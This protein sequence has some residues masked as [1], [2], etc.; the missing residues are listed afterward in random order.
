MA[1]S[2]AAMAAA[3][4]RRCARCGEAALA[5][6]H[7]EACVTV[8]SLDQQLA[9]LPD[10]QPTLDWLASHMEAGTSDMAATRLA[11]PGL[12]GARARQL[13][14]LLSG[15]ERMRVAIAG[16]AWAQPI[17]PLLLLDEPASH[18]DLDSVDALMR[19]CGTGRAPGLS[20]AMIPRGA[21]PWR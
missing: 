2:G 19:C 15:R 14:G 11:L 10:A 18:L 21:M 9:S 4:P 16:A 20:S 17:A 7:V 8:Q 13:P 6:G 12:A 5:S 3:R 1:R